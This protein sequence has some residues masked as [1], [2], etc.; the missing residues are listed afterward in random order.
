[1]NEVK[2]IDVDRNPRVAGTRISVY[3]I[4]EYLQGGWQAADVAFWLGLTRDQVDAAI[5]YIDEHREEV[6]AEFEKIRERIKQGNPP[7][8]QA[9]LDA[10]HDKL[11]ALKRRILWKRLFAPRI[12]TTA[13]RS[14]LSRIWNAWPETT[15][16]R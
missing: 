5:R 9:K 15:R 10:A 1:M 7:E 12:S 13:C 8:L 3:A 6:N 4:L 2:I 14:L 16:T 11:H